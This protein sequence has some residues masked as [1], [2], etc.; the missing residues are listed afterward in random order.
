MTPPLVVGNWKMNGSQ[1]DCLHLARQ[2]AHDVKSKPASVQVVVAPPF[3]SLAAVGKALH[4][5]AFAPVFNWRIVWNVT[6]DQWHNDQRRRDR[7]LGRSRQ[8]IRLLPQ[9]FA[10]ETTNLNTDESPAIGRRTFGKRLQL[11]RTLSVEQA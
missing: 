4:R 1:A 11:R 5:P 3:T 2:I 8:A 10:T 9:K 7:R 6:G